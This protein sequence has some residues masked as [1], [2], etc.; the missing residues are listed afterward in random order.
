[1]IFVYTNAILQVYNSTFN[2]NS[3]PGKGSV[4]NANILDVQASFTNCTFLKNSA[5]YGG[6]F[7]IESGSMVTVKRSTL[8]QNFAIIGGLA[9]VSKEGQIVLD[10]NCVITKN[11]ALSTN[12]LF[13]L[14]TNKVSVIN[15]STVETNDFNNALITLA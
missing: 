8:S 14:S 9:Y 6:V 1:M 4:L 2:E 12:L 10:D 5:T 15:N 13:I 3:S 7:Y 11:S